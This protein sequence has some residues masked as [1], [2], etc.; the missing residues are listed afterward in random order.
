MLSLRPGGGRGGS[1]FAP[2]SALSSSSS[3]DLTNAEDAPSFAVK[4]VHSF[5]LLLELLA[6]NSIPFFI[7][8]VL[9]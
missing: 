9:D 7:S 8:L 5:A 3:S 2:R 1:I 4:V 6:V